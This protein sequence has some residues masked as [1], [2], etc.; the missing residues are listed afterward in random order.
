MVSLSQRNRCAPR[1]VTQHVTR[2]R[3]APGSLRLSRRSRVDGEAASGTRGGR[4]RTDLE[5][6]P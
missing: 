3:A 1:E 4:E 5:E 2:V 6:A